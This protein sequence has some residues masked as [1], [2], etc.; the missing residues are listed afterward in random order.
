MSNLISW[1]VV[2][3]LGTAMVV[4]AIFVAPKAEFLKVLYVAA[5]L[6][7]VILTR[8]HIVLFCKMPFFR[9]WLAGTFAGTIILYAL[10]CSGPFL[11]PNWFGCLS[12]L[13][14]GLVFI[15]TLAAGFPGLLKA[16]RL[17]K[18][19]REANPTERPT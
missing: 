14:V 12:Y 18:L 16:W 7:I 2:C 15:G 17:Q 5:G 11:W 4:L 10:L 9:Y 8:I 3:V 13:C 6:T 1:R 19:T